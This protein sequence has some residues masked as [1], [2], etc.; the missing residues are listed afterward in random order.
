MAAE[1]QKFYLTTSIA[2]TNAP[3]HLGFALELI[4]ADV[5]ARY[6]RILGKD[7]FFL[8][9]TDEHGIKIAQAAQK[10]NKTPEQFTDE[11]SKEFQNLT[12]ILNI[13][14]NDFIRT[15]DKLRHWPKVQEIWL[16][17]KKNDDIEKRKYQGFY[18]VGCEAFVK[19]KD[20]IS[21]KCPIHQ[22]EP[23]KVEE[24]NY[25]FKLSKY[26][27][28]IK[29]IIEKNEVE[30]IPESR[31]NEM[32][33]FVKQG[34]EDVSFSRPIEKLKWGIPVPEDNSQTIYV[35]ADALINY[36]S[37]LD[38]PNSKKFKDFWPPDIHFLGKDILRFHATIWLGLLLSLKLD[39][40]KKI[41]VHGF[42]TSNGQ[43]MSKSLGNIVDPIELVKK[44]GAD[45]VRYFLLAEIPPTEDGDFTYER[46]EER[47]NS[48]LANGIGNLV[49]RS[50]TL[51]EK[52]WKGIIP[53]IDVEKAGDT[54]IFPEIPKPSKSGNYTFR[55]HTRFALQLI[56]Y[57]ISL[58]QFNR[59]LTD[60]FGVLGGLDKSI[61]DY[62]L[63][64]PSKKIN[65]NQISLNEKLYAV[66]EEL[67]FIAW[68]ILP[69]L[70]DTADKIFE[71]L[72][73][74]SEK[75]KEKTFEGA[76]KWGG[77]KAGSEIKKGDLLFPRI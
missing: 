57:N 31:K 13:S 4:Q 52:F 5:I 25:F 56:N 30:I 69:F 38:Y 14:N 11:I 61:N 54:W 62:A 39:L 34:L 7:V 73:L 33:S 65:N 53:N 68:L 50:T 22:K 36:L 70:P 2:Y 58:F 63:Y 32:L 23:E 18:C 64:D 77:L 15:T 55:N 8:T 40:P 12:K 16:K 59:M 48:D 26:S 74:D 43:K 76:I 29:E 35:W 51:A 67:R 72:G 37:A 9:G 45:A 20:L 21:G 49:A 42:I 6:Q 19:E 46:F 47:Y 24:E 44:Y 1:T 60:M 71:Q 17:L 41:F 66:L 27:E 75:E 28:R 3:P 10:S